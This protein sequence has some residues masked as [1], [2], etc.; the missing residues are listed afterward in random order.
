MGFLYN[1]ISSQS[2]KVRAR[3]TNWQAVP[4]L[5]NSFVTVPGKPGVADFGS[6]SAE[7]VITVRCGIYPQHSFAELVRV[8]DEMADWLNPD[9]GTQQ[10]ILDDVPDRGFSARLYEAVD[11]D[12]LIRSAGAFDLKFI[13]PDPHAYA[14]TDETYTVT[15]PG[16]RQFRRE[17]GNTAS[18]PLYSL[19]GVIRTGEKI[20][21]TTNDEELVLIGP[22]GEGE[23]LVIDAGFV[24]AKVVNSE[25]KT[26]R[27]GLPCLKELNF[28]VLYKGANT[29]RVTVDNAA[30][31]DLHIEAR[32]RWR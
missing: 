32:S 18:E 13:C 16:L 22:L 29:V 25:G 9:F 7:K 1:G 5:R 31:T 30:F 10:L 8:L 4:S 26:L 3:L 27:N 14:L 23:T 24:T 21:L 17:K 20:T 6:D 2:M 15:T 12:R 28:P 11:C 19:R